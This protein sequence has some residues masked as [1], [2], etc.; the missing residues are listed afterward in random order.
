MI[1]KKINPKTDVEFIFFWREYT[2]YVSVFSY[3]VS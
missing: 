3:R 1:R 2:H